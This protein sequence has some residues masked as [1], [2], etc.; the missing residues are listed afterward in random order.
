MKAGVT[1]ELDAL[2]EVKS[3]GQ[4]DTGLWGYRG[5]PRTLC[6]SINESIHGIPSQRVRMEIS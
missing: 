2:A 6:V 4:G 3:A 1:L 5:F